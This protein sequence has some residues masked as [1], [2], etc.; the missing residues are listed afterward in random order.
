MKPFIFRLFAFTFC[1]T[2]FLAGNYCYNLSNIKNDKPFKNFHPTLFFMGDSHIM[3]DINPAL[4]EKAINMGF[5]GEP[6]YIT[7]LKA[8]KVQEESPHKNIRLIIGIGP[9]NLSDFNEEKLLKDKHAKKIWDTYY[10]ILLPPAS[11]FEKYNLK[12]DRRS[13]FK[14]IV[15]NMCLYPKNKHDSWK[16]HFEA[17]D[18]ALNTADLQKTIQRHFYDS[19][20][21]LRNISQAAIRALDTLCN[22]S[23]AGLIAL[24]VLPVHPAYKK[25]IPPRF[26]NFFQK[27]ITK[28]ES[29]GI[30]VL[31]YMEYPL[32]DSAFYD[33]DHLNKEGARIFAPVLNADLKQLLQQG[34]LSKK[35]KD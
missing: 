18:Y 3:T 20:G 12:Y 34:E 25:K 21:R 24:V 7:Q 4:F 16:G 17:R 11:V 29:R 14:G 33:Y 10:P 9:Q 13:Y 35:Q 19:R 8:Q 22:N 27:W 31:N 6:L 1:W 2:F 15:R 5:H 28:H 32:P 23:K 26:L 30:P